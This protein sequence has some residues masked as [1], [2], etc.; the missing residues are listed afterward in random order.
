MVKKKKCRACG[1]KFRLEKENK[2]LVKKAR[3]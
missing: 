1:F 3:R 2:Y